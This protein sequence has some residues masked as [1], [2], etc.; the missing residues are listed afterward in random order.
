LKKLFFLWITCFVWGVGC[1]SGLTLEDYISRLCRLE[2]VDENLV[3]AILFSENDT[4]NVRAVNSNK[5]G[6]RDLGLFQLNSKCVDWFKEKYWLSSVPFEWA[7]PVHNA[8][9]AVKH[10]AWLSKCRHP[11]GFIFNAWLVALAYNCGYSK[12]ISKPP[13]SSIDYAQ[14]V[15][16]RLYDPICMLQVRADFRKAHPEDVSAG[17][18]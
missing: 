4:F 2:Q 15:C 1:V 6:S 13:S 10:I 5:D 8:Y 7:N 17:I 9:V 12:A 11:S 3:F 16:E 18:L 14:L